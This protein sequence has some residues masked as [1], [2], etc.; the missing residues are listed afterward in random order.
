MRII[1]SFRDYYDKGVAWGIDPKQVFVRETKE[2]NL[3]Y[4]DPEMKNDLFKVVDAMPSFK[5]CGVI[6][7]CGK[8]YPF[9][10]V[11]FNPEYDKR[12]FSKTYY[13]VESMEKDITGSSFQDNILNKADAPSKAIVQ[14]IIAD[15]KS[16]REELEFFL[17]G[18]T[19]H[20]TFMWHAIKDP[21]FARN[22]DKQLGKT[23]PDEL[24]I[25]HDV[26]IMM[27]YKKSTMARDNIA[28]LILNPR[29][30]EFNFI[31]QFDPVAAFQEIALYLGNNMARQNDP[32]ANFSDALKIN[33][34][35]FD[36]WSFRKHK[37][38]KK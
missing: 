33:S 37:D 14:G 21:N 13:S 10:K 16:L 1:S 18:R 24:F 6:G 36:K 9:W 11:H 27:A 15:I 28:A 4:N 25:R 2:L 31:S 35:G 38:D 22:F 32:S 7:F 19:S 3:A 8:C 5:T 34:H 23:L 17:T 20:R 26:P 12:G 30:N 29:L